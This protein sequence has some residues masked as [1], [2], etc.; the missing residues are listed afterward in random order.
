MTK[1]IKAELKRYISS[2]YFIISILILIYL[3]SIPTTGWIPILSNLFF[4]G[5]QFMYNNSIMAVLLTIT[6]SAYIYE[7]FITKT[8]Q[9]KIILGYKKIDLFI[10][11]TLSC[12]IGSS[13]LVAIGSIIYVFKRILRK[14]EIPF[15]FQAI[16]VNTLIFMSSIACIGIII[17]SIALIAKK[18]MITP[19]IIL[20]LTIA[21]IQQGTDTI[22]LLTFS[23]STLAIQDEN[24]T[25]EGKDLIAHNMRVNDKTRKRLNANVTLSPYAQCNYAA[26]LIIERT[27]MKSQLSYLFVGTPYH[28]DFLLSNA[29]LSTSII[30][31]GSLIF[32]NKDF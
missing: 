16:F 27:N 13:L 26:Y 31:F 30:L 18:S 21:M 19:I 10:A 3:Y 11:E 22:S 17:C 6:I 14:E 4:W 9:T 1:L 2:L 15:S 23:E 8:F 7:G 24:E 29:I 32:K 28:L 25:D 5:D 12:G 20:V